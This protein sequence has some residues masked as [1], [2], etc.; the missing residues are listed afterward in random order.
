LKQKNSAAE[1]REALKKIG[2]FGA[3]SAP[4]LLATFAPRKAIAASGHGNNGF[5][6]GGND[7]IPG[8]SGKT[9]K[10]DIYR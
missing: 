7:G 4:A 10:T 3:Y 8:N 9:G 5:G 1:R 2:L 6:N